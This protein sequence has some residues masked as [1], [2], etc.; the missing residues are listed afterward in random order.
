VA[1]RVGVLEQKQP[2]AWLP[3]TGAAGAGPAFAAGWGAP[4][5][6]EGYP[7]PAYRVENGRVW[8]RGWA[9]TGTTA[10]AAGSQLLAGPLPAAA[11]PAASHVL[12]VNNGADG[13]APVQYRL[14][15]SADGLLTFL[16]PIAAGVTLD[17]FG[18]S[19]PLT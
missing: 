14:K 3:F 5:T 2:G 18:L 9:F 8:F 10:R 4:Y 11:R 16:G 19:Y 6:G 17:L 13:V 7:A 15:A 1:A 12:R